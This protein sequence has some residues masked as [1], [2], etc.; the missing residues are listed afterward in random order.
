MLR[1]VKKRQDKE[2]H[3]PNDA[4]YAWNVSVDRDKKM[5][6]KDHFKL[7][8]DRYWFDTKLQK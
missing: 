3:Y 5:P 2:E 8:Y 4:S 7:W 1:I 6:I